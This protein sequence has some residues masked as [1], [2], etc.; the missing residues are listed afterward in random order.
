MR[1]GSEESPALKLGNLAISQGFFFKSAHLVLNHPLPDLEGRSSAV[2]EV[3]VVELRTPGRRFTTLGDS[4][5]SQ[6]PALL[7]LFTL[8]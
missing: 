5:C 1:P 6:Y 2:G 3:I 8:E 4:Q 7:R